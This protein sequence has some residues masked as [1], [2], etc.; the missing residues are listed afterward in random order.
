MCS[1]TQIFFKSET[2]L[3]NLKTL[4]KFSL[5]SAFSPSNSPLWYF[6]HFD[7]YTENHL[8]RIPF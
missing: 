7:L 5:V 3:I 6:T 1:Y 4:V 2:G 8:C